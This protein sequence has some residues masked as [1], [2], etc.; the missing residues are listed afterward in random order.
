VPWLKARLAAGQVR[1]CLYGSQSTMAELATLLLHTG[2]HRQQFRLW[3]AAPNGLAYAEE[4]L[5]DG[6][7][8]CQ[9][10]WHALG[11]DLDASLCKPGFFTAVERPRS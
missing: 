6:Y 11:R 2:I 3:V 7:G 5:K 1:P 8:A 9:Y 10:D 4:M